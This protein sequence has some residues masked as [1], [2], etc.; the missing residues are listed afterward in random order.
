MKIES[1]KDDKLLNDNTS[2]MNFNRTYM[3]A[4]SA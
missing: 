3:S 4:E 1:P 2:A